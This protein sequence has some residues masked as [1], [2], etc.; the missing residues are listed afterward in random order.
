MNSFV[1]VQIFGVV[2]L[3]FYVASL[4]QRKKEAFLLLQSGG[5]VF[6][7]LQY[8]LTNRITGAITFTLIVI[9]SLVY[10]FYKRKGLKPSIVVLII[11]QVTLIIA[12]AFS[13]QNILS[14]LPYAAS[15]GKTWGTWQDD[16]KWARITSLFAQT[17]MIV[18]NVTAAM[19]TGTFTELCNM[20][21]TSIAVWRYDI[22]GK[23]R[24]ET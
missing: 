20:T 19:Y 13:W 18:Y 5:A 7:I 12:T 21:S 23:A 22:K 1:F 4:Q 3:I 2:T 17:C 24:K 11:F 16:M 15:A 6:F 10:Y 14:L 9:R 8:I